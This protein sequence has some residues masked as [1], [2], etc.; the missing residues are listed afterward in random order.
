[1][2]VDTLGVA[3]TTFSGKQRQLLRGPMI[4]RA[5]HR[6]SIR[7]VKNL[8]NPGRNSS[9]RQFACRPHEIGLISRSMTLIAE[10]FLTLH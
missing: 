3:S 1:M 8:L 5:I 4:S 9:R 10:I 6:M 7:L 2:A